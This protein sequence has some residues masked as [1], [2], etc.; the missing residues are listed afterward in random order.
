MSTDIQF[1]PLDDLIILDD[2]REQDLISFEDLETE[3]KSSQEPRK[4]VVVAQHINSHNTPETNSSE[5]TVNHTTI[6][7]QTDFS[8]KNQK[9]YN[10]RSKSPQY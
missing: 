4:Y 8:Y 5:M 9:T 10:L 1:F 7:E 6:T 2:D 3:D